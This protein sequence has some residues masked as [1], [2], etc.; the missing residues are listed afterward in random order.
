MRQRTTC[1]TTGTHPADSLP[2]PP[3][4]TPG[5]VGDVESSQALWRGVWLLT[6][7][8]VVIDR[9][10]ASGSLTMK[11]LVGSLRRLT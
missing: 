7:D 8:I 1:R 4:L 6:G 11:R 2:W 3:R 9:T 10:G 5:Y